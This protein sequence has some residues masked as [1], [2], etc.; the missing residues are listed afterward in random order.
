MDKVYKKLIHKTAINDQKTHKDT[1]TFT[2]RKRKIK[3]WDITL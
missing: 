1:Q 3:Q 2:S